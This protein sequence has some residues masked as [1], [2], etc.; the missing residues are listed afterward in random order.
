MSKVCKSKTYRGKPCKAKPI[1]GGEYC[2]YH[3][4]KTDNVSKKDGDKNE[5]VTNSKPEKNIKSKDI[6][7]DETIEDVKVVQEN[8]EFMQDNKISRHKFMDKIRQRGMITTEQLKL[9]KIEPF[10]DLGYENC[11]P[12][13]DDNSEPYYSAEEF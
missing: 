3:I 6:N 9:I 8:E 13:Y 7:K 1:N 12:N 10:E 4:P 5:K 11:H 2:R